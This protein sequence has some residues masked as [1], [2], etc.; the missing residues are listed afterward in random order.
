M[1]FTA[2]KFTEFMLN[3]TVWVVI[4]S[5]NDNGPLAGVVAELTSLGYSV[6]VVDDCSTVP[7]A[8][9][10]KTSKVHIVRHCTNLG[11][12]AA[13]QT[14]FEFALSKHAEYLVTFDADGQHSAADI[15]A[16]LKPIRSGD[17][18]VALGSRFATG[19]QALNISPSRRIVLRLATVFT[20]LTTGL[21]ITDTHNGLRAFTADAA[22][23]I[24][25]TQNHMAH[26]SQILDQISRLSIPYAE[27]PVT[28]RY[29]EYSQTN[30]QKLSN[31]INVLWESV[32]ERLF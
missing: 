31:G 9:S 24:H 4:P 19:G 2:P 20:C 30:G 23:K 14:G 10:V 6:V 21:R 1:Y 7:V 13:L 27:V 5:F 25:I 17:A 29:T 22:R 12:G 16:L 11:Q 18:A 15:E 28:I 3:Q 8:T 32:V 26:A